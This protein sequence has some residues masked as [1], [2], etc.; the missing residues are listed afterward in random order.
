VEEEGA[1]RLA[2]PRPNFFA[3]FARIPRVTSCLRSWV[4]LDNIVFAAADGWSSTEICV[5]L[6]RTA[7]QRYC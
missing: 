4:T 1:I 3:E 2:H 5:W 6:L 7:R